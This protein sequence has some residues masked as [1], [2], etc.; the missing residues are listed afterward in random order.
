[1]DK[2]GLKLCDV[3]GRLFENSIDEGYDS[4]AFITAFMKSSVARHLDSPYDRYQWA[5]EEYLME[6][7][8][9]EVE[10]RRGGEAYPREDLYWAGYLYRYWQLL[11]GEGSREII[12]IAP[13]RTMRTNYLMFHTM[14]PELAIEDLKEIYRQ[15]HKKKTA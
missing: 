12:K 13:A 5:G 14:D 3:Q 10:I 15:R 6:E 4:E 1:M 11:T 7:L 2:I 9:D 8:G